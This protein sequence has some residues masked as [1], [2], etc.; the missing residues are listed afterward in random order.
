MVTKI[1]RCSRNTLSF[2]KIQDNLFKR[3][4]TF[5]ALDLPYSNDLATNKLIATNLSAIATFEND[6]RRARQREGIAAAKKAGK[7]RGR[8]TVID[9]KLIAKVKVLKESNNLSVTE[10]ARL[11]GKSR[12]TIYKVLKEHLGFVSNRLVKQIGRK[13]MNQNNLSFESE[14]FQIHY[15]TINL[16]FDNLKRIKNIA[17]YLSNAFDC[18]SVLIDENDFTQK[19][20]LN[21]K[22]KSYGKAE[23]RV[24]SQKYWSGTS[25]SFSGNQSTWFYKTIKRKGL[26]WEVLDFDNTNLSR[27]DLYYDR[28]LKKS[29]EIELLI[30]LEKNAVVKLKKQTSVKQ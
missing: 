2:L 13:Q 5:V 27:I 29:D 19:R 1:D 7:Y 18:N 22:E 23:F 10:I 15:L 26:D 3:S 21:K 11:T 9:S 20:T 12:A 8:K 16:Q 14:S 24:N 4:I 28:K 6:R 17:D 25:L 30:H